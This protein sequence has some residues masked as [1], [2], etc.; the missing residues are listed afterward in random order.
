MNTHRSRPSA[1]AR[2]AAL[3]R[4]RGSSTV[5]LVI[6]TPVIILILLF[7]VGLGRYAYGRQ[8]VEQAGMAAA[9]SAALA[10]SAVDAADRAQAAGQA[11]LDSAGLACQSL[12]VAT[13]ARNFTPGG[14]VTVTLSCT[15][16]NSD[17]V[18]A[19]LPGQSTV[20]ATSTVPLETYRQIA[21]AGR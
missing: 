8:L 18:M 3:Q 11:S 9:R 14:T 7:L 19:G 12:D 1:S 13:D 20:T 21:A 10:S 16:N 4:D 5:E 2:T 17:A 15:V 6:L